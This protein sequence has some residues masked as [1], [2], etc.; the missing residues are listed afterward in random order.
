MPIYG[1]K[2]QIPITLQSGE[3]FDMSKTVKNWHL[4]AHQ[5]ANQSH[6]QKSKPG[7]L[8][9]PRPHLWTDS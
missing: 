7:Y 4:M 5:M 9:H 3:L 1:S 6:I 2:F 8:E